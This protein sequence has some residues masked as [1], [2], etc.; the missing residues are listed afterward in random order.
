M[1]DCETA[2]GSEADLSSVPRLPLGHPQHRGHRHHGGACD[3]AGTINKGNKQYYEEHKSFHAIFQMNW[4]SSL[5]PMPDLRL[6]IAEEVSLS[7]VTTQRLEQI[8]WR[9]C[10][11]EM[12]GYLKTGTSPEYQLSHIKLLAWGLAQYTTLLWLDTDTLVVRGLHQ[13]FLTGEKR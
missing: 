6:L 13:L 1:E 10:R 3:G 8:G 11:V 9:L 2:A 7:E 5:H 4:N 12:P